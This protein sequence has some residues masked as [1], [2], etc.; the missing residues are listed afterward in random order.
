MMTN[1]PPPN[2]QSTLPRAARSASGPGLGD[3]LAYS[4][5]GGTVARPR[6][7]AR[8]PDDPFATFIEWDGEADR[9]AYDGL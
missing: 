5:D 7:S 8:R 4:I 6:A 3:E 1:K 9:K 2:A